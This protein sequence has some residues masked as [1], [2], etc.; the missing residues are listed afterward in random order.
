MV[1]AASFSREAKQKPQL[2]GA[3]RVQVLKGSADCFCEPTCGP[4]R[5]ALDGEARIHRPL[6]GQGRIKALKDAEADAIK[7][8]Q[9]HQALSVGHGWWPSNY[10]G[11]KDGDV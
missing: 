5:L 11:F 4:L 7:C 9:E 2:P 8:F 3:K 6:L 10:K 1:F